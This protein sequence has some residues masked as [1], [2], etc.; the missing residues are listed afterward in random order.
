MLECGL[1]ERL[2]A[3]TT[4]CMLDEDT[5]CKPTAA[6]KEVFIVDSKVS[7]RISTTYELVNF[8]KARRRRVTCVA[9]VF[10]V[11]ESIICQFAFYGGV[12]VQHHER[13]WLPVFLEAID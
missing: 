7:C 11:A 10:H 4:L 1:V 6:V 3:V 2:G 9:P 12:N 5:V 8:Q 13:L